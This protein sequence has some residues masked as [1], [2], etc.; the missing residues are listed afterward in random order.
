MILNGRANDMTRRIMYSVANNACMPTNQNKNYDNDSRE[1]GANNAA[2]S[3]HCTGYDNA[4]N[5]NFK[6][7]NPFS[8][9]F[10]FSMPGSFSMYITYSGSTNSYGQMQ[11]IDPWYPKNDGF[12]GLSANTCNDKGRSAKKINNIRGCTPLANTMTCVKDDKTVLC[13]GA[14]GPRWFTDIRP[15][16]YRFSGDYNCT[17]ERKFLCSGCYYCSQGIG[18][19]DWSD[20]DG[21]L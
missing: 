15:Y 19:K 21:G 20:S 16:Y 12:D 1:Q 6:N 17:G 4:Y 3:N 9:E 13:P 10:T 18:Y 8:D 11:T 7:N 14:S 5:A 2:Y